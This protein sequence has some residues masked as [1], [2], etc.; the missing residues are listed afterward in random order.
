M[1]LKIVEG[2]T[3]SKKVSNCIYLYFTNV[4]ATK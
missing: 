3:G 1:E 4:I 2:N